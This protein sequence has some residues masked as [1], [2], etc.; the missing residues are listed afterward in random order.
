MPAPQERRMHD[1]EHDPSSDDLDIEVSALPQRH[2]VGKRPAVTQ[3]VWASVQSPRG[4]AARLVFTG[5]ILVLAMPL[6]V[7]TLPSIPQPVLPLLL[8]PPPLP[9][10]IH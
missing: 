7:L 10:T 9:I 8:S 2:A 3:G 6:L 4:R 1:S 5:C